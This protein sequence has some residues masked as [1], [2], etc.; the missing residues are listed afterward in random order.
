MFNLS[1]KLGT[2]ALKEQIRSHRL[3]AL[4]STKERLRL[5][6][7]SHVFCVWDFQCLLKGLQNQFT[8]TSIPWFPTEDGEA[9][10]LINEI[11][12]EEESDEHP[13]YGYASHFEIY[14]DA[15]KEAGCDVEGILGFV[16]GIS[17]SKDIERTIGRLK[18]HQSLKEFL[19]FTL[20]IA[21]HAKPH[22]MTAVFYE[23]RENMVP[24]V[25]QQLLEGLPETTGFSLNMFKYYLKRHIEVD[26]Q[27]HGPMSERLLMKICKSEDDWA[28]CRQM[29]QLALEKRLN[30][31]EALAENMTLLS[32]K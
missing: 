9:R 25:F 14:L 17:Q 32:I 22:V 27:R 28:D 15:M 4:I 30:L 1:S 12:L 13:S 5:F 20:H 11:V 23:S 19:R 18:L 31:W 16:E 7:E 10:R 3:Y 29:A 2:Q 21:T 24:Q 8:C 26:G 6:M